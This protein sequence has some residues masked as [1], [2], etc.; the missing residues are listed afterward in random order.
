[1]KAL[2]FS[3]YAR[4]RRGALKA[5]RQSGLS[6]SELRVKHFYV[7]RDK[8]VHYGAEVDDDRKRE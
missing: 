7:R 3:R 5:E 1:M 8:E 2:V 6:L 4:F